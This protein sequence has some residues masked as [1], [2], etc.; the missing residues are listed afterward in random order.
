MARNHAEVAVR[1]LGGVDEVGRGSCRRERGGK[2]AAEVAR[3]ADAG[4]NQTAAAVEN[5][6]YGS[7][8]ILTE[9][10]CYDGKSGSLLT[11]D[12]SSQL[13]GGIGILAVVH[14]C[15]LQA[16]KRNQSINDSEWKGTKPQ[17][18]KSPAESDVVPDSWTKN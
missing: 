11:E 15:S 2:L 17:N 14:E 12:F 16:K 4:N 18:M 7:C 8:E 6:R 9:A 10:V 3:F 1:S 5:E 13:Q